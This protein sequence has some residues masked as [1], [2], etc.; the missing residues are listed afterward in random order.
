MDLCAVDE[1]YT[2]EGGSRCGHGPAL[3]NRG[4]RRDEESLHGEIRL[5]TPPLYLVH[6]C[7][8]RCTTLKKIL[9]PLWQ[10]WNPTK[11]ELEWEWFPWFK[12]KALL[13]PLGISIAAQ[14][15]PYHCNCISG[16]AQHFKLD[17]R[18]IFVQVLKRIQILLP[19]LHHVYVP[20]HQQKIL[21]K[22]KW[23]FQCPTCCMAAK[24]NIFELIKLR[25]H[26]C[27]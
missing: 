22:S 20:P 4:L 10:A 23:A 17:S 9:G 27:P 25:G 24:F 1:C 8:L 15:Y 13:S 19:M 2:I 18:K 14:H 7:R 16:T 6:T 26:W 21:P 12:K 5:K 11:V 3:G